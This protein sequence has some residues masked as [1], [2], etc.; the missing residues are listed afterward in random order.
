MTAKQLEAALVTGEVPQRIRPHLQV[1]L[2]EAPVSL[3]AKAPPGIKNHVETRMNAGPDDFSLP[4][5]PTKIPT[6]LKMLHCRNIPGDS[7]VTQ[8]KQLRQTCSAV[9]LCTTWSRTAQAGSRYVV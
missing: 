2:D 9:H 8:H 4:V 7:D 3:L 6:K 5:I 1:L